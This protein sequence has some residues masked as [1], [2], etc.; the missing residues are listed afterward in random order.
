VA[1]KR[2]TKDGAIDALGT[3]GAMARTILAAGAAP[4]AALKQAQL[5]LLDTLGCGFAGTQEAV[6]QA[7]WRTA[8]ES[9]EAGQCAVIGREERTSVLGAVLANGAAIRV[10]DLNDYIIGAAANGE[11]ESGG[12]PSDNIPVALAAGSARGRSGRDVLEAIVIGYELYS[13]LQ[14]A[15]DRG[16]TID[17][18]TVSGLVAP[19]MAGRLMVLSEEQL[20]HALALGAAR[21]VTP[22]IVRSGK[23][24]AAKSIANAMVAQS[25]VQAALLAE[26]GVTGPLA[27]LDDARGLSDFFGQRD[28]AH[29]SAAVA[30]DSTIM[31][32]HVKAYPC[33]NTGQ[34]AVAAALKLHK[35]I[36]GRAA[37]LARIEVTMADYKVTK[38]HQED[39]GRIRPATREAADHSFPF[40]VAVTLIDG[41]FGVPQ[42]K[43][44]RWQDDNVKALMEKIVLRRDA[45]WN[46][47][48]PG[49]YPCS[50]RAWNEAGRVFEVEV[51][52]PP[53]F[54]Q[55]GLHAA[56]VI[57]NFLALTETVL[58]RDEQQ[59]IVDRVM[60]FDQALSTVALD[61]AIAIKG[62]KK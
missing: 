55:A 49:T 13:R 59:R 1:G 42:F 22:W 56:A 8:R 6:A 11:P 10:L 41:A 35:M 29:L 25:G 16:G 48:A 54:S 24:S 20:S 39:P 4:A 15:M 28:K 58:T 43:G 3:I 23:I 32:A 60:E 21:A 31:H 46:A 14:R 57:E 12:H 38:R 19:A 9:G 2:E 61:S 5:L 26:R 18:V 44:K 45:G 51:P 53:G 62:T 36:E 47:R 34:S 30:A 52:Y 33:I 40:L 37:D 7:V 27:I 17:G 50:I